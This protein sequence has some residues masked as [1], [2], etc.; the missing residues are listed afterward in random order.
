M[1]KLMLLLI[2]LYSPVLCQ[3]RN[4]V[5]SFCNPANYLYLYTFTVLLLPLGSAVSYPGGNTRFDCNSFAQRVI[6]DVQWLLN[7]LPFNNL[8]YTN[9]TTDF[10]RNSQGVVRGSALFFDDIPVEYNMTTIACTIH[11]TTG[12]PVNSS[13]NTVLLLQG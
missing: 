1:A 4:N 10:A 13:M 5:A 11:Y 9:V 7:G 3:G 8:T 2:F 12:P 6:S